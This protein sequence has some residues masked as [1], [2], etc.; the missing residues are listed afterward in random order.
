MKPRT[1]L[2]SV[3]GKE[4]GR[5]GEENEPVLCRGDCLLCLLVTSISNTHD[6][7]RKANLQKFS[8]LFF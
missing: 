3:E 6:C 1:N 4:S 2:L 7:R 8:N 5:E